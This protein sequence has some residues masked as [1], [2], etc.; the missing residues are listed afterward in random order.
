MSAS[1]WLEGRGMGINC[2]NVYKNDASMIAA[3]KRLLRNRARGPM[4][5]IYVYRGGQAPG[6]DTP[7]IGRAGFEGGGETVTWFPFDA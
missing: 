4:S 5:E 3:A 6:A 1:Y 2:A 7:A